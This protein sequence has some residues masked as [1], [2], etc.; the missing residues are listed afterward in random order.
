MQF[1]ASLDLGRKAADLDQEREIVH[2]RMQQKLHELMVR[3]PAY[4]HHAEEVLRGLFD[5]FAGELV[6]AI[7][8]SC[9]DALAIIRAISNHIQVSLTKRLRNASIAARDIESSVRKMKRGQETPEY[10]QD[11]LTHLSRL[12]RRDVSGHPR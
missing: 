9:A 1:H 6:N 8:F 5:P 11:I 2:L 10:S 3:V 7:G 4:P 12:P